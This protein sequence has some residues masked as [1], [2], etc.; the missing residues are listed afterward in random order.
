[1]MLYTNTVDTKTLDLLKRLMALPVLAK[2]ALVGGTNLSLQLGHRLSVDLDIFSNEDFIADEVLETVI[3]NFS[4]FELIRSS[5]K[6]FS[7]ILENVKIDIILHKYDYLESVKVIDGI[8]LLSIPDII[9]MKLNAM[10]Q[11][12]AKKDFWDIAE[13][14]NHYSIEEMLSFFVRKY[15]NHDYGYIIHS[16]YYFD[17][18]EIETDPIDLKGV[19]WQEVKAKIKKATDEFVHRKL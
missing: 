4:S 14:L 18:A 9:P 16:L 3:Q 12:G 10:A 6:S 7:G 17:D 19:T 5:E 15:K 2:F 11:R 13:L 1:M 8:R